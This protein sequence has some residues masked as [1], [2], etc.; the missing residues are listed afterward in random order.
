[1]L[2]R[3]ADVAFAVEPMPFTGGRLEDRT[4]MTRDLPP[5]ENEGL[6]FRV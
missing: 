5:G 4:G 2:A 6:G 3:S 1:M